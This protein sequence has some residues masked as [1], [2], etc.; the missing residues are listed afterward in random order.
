MVVCRWP[1]A[2][3][4]P[5]TFE[6]TLLATSW[7]LPERMGSGTLPAENVSK[8]VLYAAIYG[9]TR[10][11]ALLS[12]GPRGVVTSTAPVVAPAGTVAS[13]CVSDITVKA[14]AAPLNATLVILLRSFS[15]IFTSFPTLPRARS[16]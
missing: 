4:G 5:E 1:L 9:I 8:L 12:S 15:R 11:A 6:K 3:T 10:N 16:T 13:I 14:A 2:Q 7:Q